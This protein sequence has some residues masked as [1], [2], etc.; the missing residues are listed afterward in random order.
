MVLRSLDLLVGA[1]GADGP[2]SDDDEKA[3]SRL[4]ED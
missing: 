4:V 3:A 2:L 1:S